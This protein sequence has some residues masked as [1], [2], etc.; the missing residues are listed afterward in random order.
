MRVIFVFQKSLDNDRHQVT[1]RRQG[2]DSYRSDFSER[3]R[4]L[5]I[6][7]DKTPP[8]LL[9]S[10]PLQGELQ[11]R[12]FSSSGAFSAEL[13][14]AVSSFSKEWGGMQGVGEGVELIQPCHRFSEDAGKGPGARKGEDPLH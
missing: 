8:R 1:L 9:Q 7:S 2:F 14:K 3:Q 12:A 11:W 4:K 6:I 13:S 10:K 5:A